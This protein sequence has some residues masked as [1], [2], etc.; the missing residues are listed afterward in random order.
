[1]YLLL[2]AILSIKKAAVEK[3]CGHVKLLV[4]GWVP[5]LLGE[6]LNSIVEPLQQRDIHRVNEHS[7]SHGS[8][9]PDVL[10]RRDHAIQS[11]DSRAT[12]YYIDK[13]LNILC[14]EY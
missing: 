2:T 14:Q 3:D 11:M 6:F 7:L 12:H 1:M 9:Y 4:K 10:S 13:N 8:V 5:M